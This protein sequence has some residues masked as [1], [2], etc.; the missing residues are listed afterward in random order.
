[1]M[2][3]H[4]SIVLKKLKWWWLNFIKYLKIQGSYPENYVYDEKFK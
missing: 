3:A 4:I 1:M 2:M